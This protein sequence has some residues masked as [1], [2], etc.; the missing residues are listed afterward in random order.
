[1]LLDFIIMICN[2]LW[3]FS[4]DPLN[5]G[6]NSVEQETPVLCIFTFQ[7]P[8]RTQ[9]DLG[10]FLSV[11]ILSREPCGAQEVNKGGHGGQTRPGGMG[12]GPG[13]A[14]QARLSLRPP[15]PSIFVS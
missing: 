15:M 5:F 1:M 14:T 6:Y 10:F 8:C 7:E 13:H 9:I 4:I 3:G 2:D 11:N 12:S